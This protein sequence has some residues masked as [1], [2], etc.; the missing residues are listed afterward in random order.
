VALR[1]RP[2]V[3]EGG[4]VKMGIYQEVS[5]IR[6]QSNPN[7]IILNKRALE[8]QVVIDDGQ[9]LVLGGLIADDVNSTVQQVP[10][11]GS[12]PGIGSL[13]RY[14]T[15]Q[16]EKVNLMVF[17]RPYVIRDSA[18]ANEITGNRYEYIREVQGGQRLPQRFMLPDMATPQLPPRGTPG[19]MQDPSAPPLPRDRP[20]GAAPPPPQ[21]AA[22]SASRGPVET[23]PP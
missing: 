19:P 11:L 18:T 1:V 13:F 8:S 3:A 17:L 23:S 10:L 12:I 16:R 9:I 2:Q 7:G 14:S 15:R 6:D 20:L 4:A 22:P 21:P 5:S